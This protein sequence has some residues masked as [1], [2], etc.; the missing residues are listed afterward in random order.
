MHDHIHTLQKKL[1]VFQI[2]KKIHRF[3]INQVLL[4]KL[5]FKV[6]K[7]DNKNQHLIS[8][9]FFNFYVKYKI[10]ISKSAIFKVSTNIFLMCF[11]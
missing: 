5:A 3:G 11:I 6:K 7:I 8:E 1:Q 2:F 9:L 4:Y 10:I